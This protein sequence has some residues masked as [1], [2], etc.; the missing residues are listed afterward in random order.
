MKILDCWAWLQILATAVEWSSNVNRWRSNFRG[1]KTVSVA[2]QPLQ[3]THSA[4]RLST[5]WLPA[6]SIH[7]KYVTTLCD[8]WTFCCCCVDA[9]PAHPR[10]VTPVC[11]L[12]PSD[13]L[14]PHKVV[15]YVDSS[16]TRADYFD[17]YG[18]R[19]YNAIKT[20]L[21]AWCENWTYNN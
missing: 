18:K 16:R 10:G 14:G 11:N 8:N 21:N 5:W 4:V 9:L 17:S 6:L 7:V 20:Y 19:P 13:Q 1:E 15:I 3:R 2:R 12:V